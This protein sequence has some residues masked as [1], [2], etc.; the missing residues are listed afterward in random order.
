MLLVLLPACRQL[1]E[2]A[3]TSLSV[4]VGRFSAAQPGGPFLDGWHPLILSRFKKPTQYRLVSKD[5]ITVVAAHA[6]ASAS[7]L[8]HD[9]DI[10]VNRY[11]WLEWRWLVPSIIEQAD[12]TRAAA[13]DSPARVVLS[14]AGDA[15][16][17]PFS[18]RLFM[19]ELKALTG[20][21]LPYATL[22]YIWDS[23]LAPGTIVPNPHTARIQMVVAQSGDHNAGR[24]IAERHNVLEDYRAA[25]GS[26]PKRLVSIGVMSD[27]DNTGATV[28]AY[29]GDLSFSQPH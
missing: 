18:D 23:R 4:G 16:T 27:A 26:D 19:R 7:G 12:S 14:F 1:P 22:M 17:L 5:G 13:E 11:P 25:F 24:W 20:R 28:E 21:Q 9:V 3:A 10:D 8:A 15:K 2:H 6:S 29:Y